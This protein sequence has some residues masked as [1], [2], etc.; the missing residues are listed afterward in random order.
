MII[1][2]KSSNKSNWRD[3]HEDFISTIRAARQVTRAVQEGKPLP[4]P[5]PSKIDPSLV[6]CQYCQRR[7]NPES[8]ERHIKFCKEQTQ[9][10]PRKGAAK[11]QLNKRTQVTI[12]GYT[13]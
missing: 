3:K 5:P 13:V 6:Q 8:A 1:K 7:F 10:L 11:Q 2:N 12:R 9:R 4:P